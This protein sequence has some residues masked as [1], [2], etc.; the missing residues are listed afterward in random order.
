MREYTYIWIFVVQL[1]LTIIEWGWAQ[2]EE[3]SSPK[4]ALS[5]EYG[6]GMGRDVLG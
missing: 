1:Q 6:Q 3:L 4:L 2:Y 5:T